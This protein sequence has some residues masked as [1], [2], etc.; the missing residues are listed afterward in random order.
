MRIVVFFEDQDD[1]NFR[2]GKPGDSSG[3]NGSQA[4]RIHFAVV[5]V[6]GDRKRD[7]P[8]LLLEKRRKPAVSVRVAVVK[9]H[10]R[11][12]FISARV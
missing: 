6:R 2:R 10:L 3:C 12:Q 11:F 1:G 8:R 9:A 5:C 7:Y 4:I